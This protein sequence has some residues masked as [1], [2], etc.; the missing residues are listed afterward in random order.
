MAAAEGLPRPDPLPLVPTFGEGEST[1]VLRLASEVDVVAPAAGSD[2]VVVDEPDPVVVEPPGALA[3]SPPERNP[4]VV[5]EEHDL[6]TGSRPASF[7]PVDPFSP[8]SRP[9]EATPTRRELRRQRRA[10]RR[11]A[12]PTARRWPRRLAVLVLLLALVAGGGA[13]WWFL[14]RVPVHD[15]PDL[16][17][18][19]VQEAERIA[20]RHNWELE[21]D[22]LDRRDGT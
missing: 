2:R 21:A 10:E 9:N 11:A 16:A 7:G 1:L 4:I 22:R 17:G 14:I 12:R 5:A 19:T 6:L 3:D 18:M 8:E 15:V 20:D 13:A